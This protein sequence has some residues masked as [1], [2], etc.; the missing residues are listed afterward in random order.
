MIP[1][2]FRWLGRFS[3][4]SV[5]DVLDCSQP[6]SCLHSRLPDLHLTGSLDSKEPP[7]LKP[8]A[9]TTLAY[10]PMSDAYSSSVKE[11]CLPA[12]GE[13][14]LASSSRSSW[15]L[16]IRPTKY[17]CVKTRL[18]PLLYFKINFLQV[19]LIKICLVSIINHS[20]VIQNFVYRCFQCFL[21]LIHTTWNKCFD[22]LPWIPIKM[23][24]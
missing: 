5:T 17:M 19:F 6:T 3:V 16:L 9:V 11:C 8:L 15:L 7:R 21:R 23:R 2:L 12:V 10:I 14:E 4:L 24:F 13:Y 1:H 22:M 18:K 20:S